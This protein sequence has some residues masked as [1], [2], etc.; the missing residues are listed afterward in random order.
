VFDLVHHYITNGVEAYVYWNMVLEPGGESTWGWKQ[1]S[2]V[3]VDP[4]RRRARYNPEFYV[5]KHFSAFVEPG[6]R[7]LIPAGPWAGNA[8]AFRKP[9]GR[10]VY[11]VHNPSSEPDTVCIGGTPFPLSPQ[12]INT[13]METNP[14]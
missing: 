4:D 5:M 11:V 8:L 3:T 10:T 2:L 13:F 9:D 6:D 12:S 1:N 7:V 14:A